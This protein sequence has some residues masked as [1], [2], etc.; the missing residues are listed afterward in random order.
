VTEQDII[1]GFGKK[2]GYSFNN[3]QLL[4][5]ALTHRSYIYSTD[6][7]VKSNERLEYLGDSV[8]GLVVA[9][10]LFLSNPEYAEGDLTKTKALL[11][12]ETTLSRVAVETGLNDFVLMSPEEEKSG[13][14][15]R[16][17]IVSDAVEAVIG[18]IYLDG[19][20]NSATHFIERI[21][22]SRSE[23]ILSDTTQVNYK[24]ELLEYMQSLGAEPPYY[25]VVSEEGP[26][27]EKIFTVVVHT[28]GE[29]TGTGV[30]A[31]K[32]EAEQHAARFSL[33]KIGKNNLKDSE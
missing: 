29:I 4:I 26:D 33:E 22:L 13:G 25:E 12:N 8:L 9:E 7:S 15:E 28:R 21:I 32:K 6:N 24:G 2:F 20:L 11:V 10:H 5:E 1:S 31:S 23:V 18:A 17:S 19:G 3:Q 16:N 27:H 30:G 14:R